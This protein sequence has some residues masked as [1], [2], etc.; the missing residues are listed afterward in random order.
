MAGGSIDEP[1][2]EVIQEF[3]TVSPT[4][5]TPTLPTVVVGPCIQVVDAFDDDGVAQ[6]AALAGTYRDGVGVISYDLPGLSEGALLTSLS[7][8]IRVFLVYG[9]VVRELHSEDDEEEISS[10][11]TGT[12]TLSGLTFE[13][14]G[15]LWEQQGVEVGDYVR[16]SYRGESFDFPITVVTSDT[17]LTLGSAGPIIDASLSGLTFT[18]VRSPAEFLFSSGSQANAEYG[19][20][21]NFIRF[22]TVDG[23]EY[24]GAAGDDLSLV[25]SD[26][27]HY[28][29]GVGGA[30]G[31]GIF[32][33]ASGAFS[34]ITTTGSTKVPTTNHFLVMKA[35][36]PPT[37][38]AE[39][40]RQ[41]QRV[42]SATV[43]T[44]ET[45]EGLGLASRHYFLGRQVAV[46]TDMGTA[47]GVTVTSASATFQTTIPGFVAGGS[48]FPFTPTTACYIEIEA[49]GVYE[50]SAVASA[51][52]LTLASATA[53]TATGLD[54]VVAAE[55]DTGS[56][57]VTGALTD[58]VAPLGGLNDI[59]NTAGTP[60][61]STHISAGQGASLNKALTS[62]TSDT[63]AVIAAWAATAN[64]LTWQAADS[65]A[66]LSV[67]FQPSS[68][69]VTITLE[70]IAG[71]SSSTYDDIE[72]LITDDADPGFNPVVSAFLT[73]AVTGSGTILGTTVA[74]GNSPIT[75]EFDGGADDNDLLLD[76]DL[77]ASETPTASVYVSY[78]ALRVD[79]AGGSELS[80]LGEVTSVDEII[81]LLGAISVENPLA[82]GCFFALLGS[83][84]RPIRFI[85]V[86]AVTATKPDGTAEAYT[87]AFQLLEAFDVYTIIPLTQ[88]PTVHGILDAHVTAMSAST[89]KSER[90][91]FFSTTLPTFTQADVIASGFDGNTEAG[92]TAD[93]TAEFSASVDFDEAG[94]EAGD[95]LVVTALATPADSPDLVDGTNELYGIVILGVKTGNNFILELDGTATGVGTDWNSLIDVDFAI[96][97]SGTAIS[98]AAAQSEEVA[99]VG[100]GYLNRRMFHSWPDEGT[101]D[102]NGTEQILEGFYIAAGWGGKVGE[103]APQQGFTNLTLP[104]WTGLHHSNG[105]FSKT[106]LN[107]IAGGGTFISVQD[108]SAAPIRCRHQLST[109]TSSLQVREL[110]IT[111][112]I[113]YIARFIRLS[114]VKHVGRFNITQQYLDAL[115]TIMQGILR[116]LIESGRVRD[117]RLLELSADDLQTDKINI[118]VAVDVFSPA[119]Y[120]VVTV[121]I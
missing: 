103:A 33:S 15:A 84:T 80:A 119:N 41:V 115:A 82:L 42:V 114:L 34:G 64:E 23:S 6:A 22:T 46:G 29:T 97:R 88:D 90:I 71:S 51:T 4:I 17:L 12:F 77:L 25:I 89:A 9:A 104:G 59:P 116:N 44:I 30:V 105:Y 100:E 68:G 76:A 57:G 63:R 37:G 38:A 85:G 101:A 18:I 36:S 26:S 108:S 35:T 93:A 21:G 45:G 81:E 39:V 60:D 102:V 14:P 110:S 13:Q 3:V 112:V 83:P 99:K 117:A 121:Q 91:G 56:D 107:R 54:Y 47:T 72:T 95:I 7:D 2:V 62:I 96:Y 61:Q 106:Q 43:L 31:D 19:I 120:I 73:A 67:T 70:R 1:G 74:Y 52:S 75:L 111:K 27:F 55:V 109:D 69:V 48:V 113:D 40:F 24:E 8:L 118:K 98:A 78:R 11:T 53:G 86:N 87:R 10:G 79:V 32:S 58:F 65:A 94:V 50:V 28:A 49:D 92:F 20:T 66:D 16:F 5:I